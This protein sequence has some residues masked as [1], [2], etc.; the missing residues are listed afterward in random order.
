MY[1]QYQ[2]IFKKVFKSIVFL[3]NFTRQK[4]ATHTVYMHTP[5]KWFNKEEKK[6][7]ITPESYK[8]ITKFEMNEQVPKAKR[9]DVGV[10]R[11]GSKCSGK[12]T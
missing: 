2:Q 1:E 6:I 12:Y 7:Y 5:V 4:K 9:A 10:D 11:E 8:V 3:I